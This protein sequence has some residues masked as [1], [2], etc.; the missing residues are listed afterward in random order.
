MAM[1]N[2]PEC[3]KEISDKAESCI[4]CG[5]PLINT[6]CIKEF[7]EELRDQSGNVYDNIRSLCGNLQ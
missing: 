4:H 2:C 7:L 5:F 3:E 1:I 6:K